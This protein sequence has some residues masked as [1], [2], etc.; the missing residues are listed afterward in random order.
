MN[1]DSAGGLSGA[2]R[3]RSALYVKCVELV[4]LIKRETYNRRQLIVTKLPGKILEALALI[5]I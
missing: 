3:I 2:K 5:E 1:L 4:K